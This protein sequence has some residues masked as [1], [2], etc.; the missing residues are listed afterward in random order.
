MRN[1]AVEHKVAA[2]SE[3]CCTLAGKAKRRLVL[4]VTALIYCQIVTY[5]SDG[6]NLAE[7]ID[8]YPL[9]VVEY[10]LG[11]I[12]TAKTVRYTEYLGVRYS[13]VA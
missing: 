3:L 9:G 13:G 10:C 11:T 7:K 12:G 8:E 2:F 4:R 1:P 5:S 6:D